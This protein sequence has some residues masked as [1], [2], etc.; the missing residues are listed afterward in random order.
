MSEKQAEYKTSEPVT[1]A[2]LRLLRRVRGLHAGNHLVIIQIT[3]AGVSGFSLLT[4]GKSERLQP[5][6][7]P[8]YDQ[9]VANETQ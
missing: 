2:E 7:P 1:P 8:G 5:G 4:S 3:G 9:G 6:N